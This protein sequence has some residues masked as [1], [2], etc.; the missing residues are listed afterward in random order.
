MSSDR[1]VI[2]ENQPQTFTST[3][4]STRSDGNSTC[5]PTEKIQTQP[6]TP[7]LM[8]SDVHTSVPCSEMIDNVGIQTS[9]IHDESS[10]T[11]STT[12]VGGGEAPEF[13]VKLR[14]CERKRLRREAAYQDYQAK[15][16]QKRQEV[17]KRRKEQVLAS[18]VPRAP[19]A[20]VTPMNDGSKHR[21]VVDMGWDKEMKPTELTNA[22]TQVARC[23]SINR[24]ATKPV[25]LYATDISEATQKSFNKSAPNHDNWDM[26][27]KPEGYMSEFAKEDLVYLTADSPNVIESID[28]NKVYIIG[29]IVDHNRLKDACYKR[30]QEQGIA[31]GQLPISE[32]IHMKTRRVL[33]INHVFEIL[34]KFLECNDWKKAFL[35]ILPNRK[36]IEGVV[37]D[38]QKKKNIQDRTVSEDV[39]S[40][41]SADQQMKVHT[42]S[43]CSYEGKDD[44]GMEEGKN[45]LTTTELSM[46]V[47]E[48]IGSATTAG[49]EMKVH[50][51][52]VCVGEGGDEDGIEE[53]KDEVTTT[54][55]DKSSANGTETTE[56][57]SA[58]Y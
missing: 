7:V 34:V 28:E 46:N 54:N 12:I 23:Y 24:R 56:V 41:T 10:T 35:E 3:S 25:Q 45:V 32:H 47:S 30:A 21:I 39:G 42:E 38:E 5:T 6:T 18:G 44:N 29:G 1:S 2:A 11:V 22:V 55:A 37:E 57:E 52:S 50:T 16:K 43:V 27:W 33:T 8:V 19:R 13:P 17:K 40:A 49:Q 20:R 26:H 48:D 31:H 14:A 4:A 9:N 53:G 51:A 58:Q 36:R 15:K